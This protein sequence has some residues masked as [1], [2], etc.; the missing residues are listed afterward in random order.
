MFI[1]Q[2]SL[3]SG[4]NY[5]LLKKASSQ[6]EVDKKNGIKRRAIVLY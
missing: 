2:T 4:F 6:K 3:V 1:G 5:L